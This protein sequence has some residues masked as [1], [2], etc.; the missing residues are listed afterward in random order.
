MHL[1]FPQLYIRGQNIEEVKSH[2]VL[3]A[4]ID[5]DLSWS[6]HI[7]ELG[8]RISTRIYQLRKIKNFLNLHSRKLF[9][10]AHILSLINYASTLWD[11]TSDTN[12]R[13]IS[14]LHK[15]AI[16]LIKL[17]SNT[18]TRDDYRDLDIL[19]LKDRLF[20]NKCLCMYNVVK[21]T[22]PKKIVN[23]FTINENR[24]SHK[25]SFP[26][27]RNNLYKSSLLYSGGTIWNNLPPVL[28]SAPSKQSFK[29]ALKKYLMEK[30]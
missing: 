26:R 4:I 14:R 7:A 23:S 8:K 15:R 1:P 2:K 9:F 5:N 22:A 11:N 3:G 21:R 20:Y 28:K 6:D 27:P 17:S 12:L 30:L 10:H 29:K 19:P 13:Y 25:L 18:L 24:H 16:K